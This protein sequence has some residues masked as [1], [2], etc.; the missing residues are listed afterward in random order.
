M[1]Q[2]HGSERTLMLH[3]PQPESRIIGPARAL[4][5]D[6]RH[7]EALSSHDDQ[8]VQAHPDG[9]SG[10]SSCS[11]PAHVWLFPHAACY[12]HARAALQRQC[13]TH[14]V[15]L[16][17]RCAHWRRLEL[18]GPRSSTML[19]ALLP[20]QQQTERL[21]SRPE[22]AV[23]AG[24]LS[25]PRLNVGPDL[26]AAGRHGQQALDGSP[27]ADVS[28]LWRGAEP[29]TPPMTDQQVCTGDPP[30]LQRHCLP[31]CMSL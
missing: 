28:A 10:K 13:E 12:V 24:W 4:L 8:S 2:L 14:G 19:A 1:E 30:R 9:V 23:L 3:E 16:T 7:C 22:G 27:G 20:G 31:H 17:G 15:Q 21:N 11:E 6:M 25:D 5:L 18:R 26:M 29:L